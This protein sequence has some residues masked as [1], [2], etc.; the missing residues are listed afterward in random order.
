MSTESTLAIIQ[1]VNNLAQLL[2]A[3]QIS[4]PQLLAAKAR[5][6]AEGRTFGQA[7]VDELIVKSRKSL[8]DFERKLQEWDD[9]GNGGG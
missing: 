5:A 4:F 6:E 2:Q 7:D 3:A 8:E 9:S 1:L